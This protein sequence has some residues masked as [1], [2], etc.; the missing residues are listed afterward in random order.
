MMASVNGAGESCPSAP[1]SI[2]AESL[3]RT[4]FLTAHALE[5]LEICLKA[6]LNMAICG[7]AGSGKRALLHA[8]VPRMAGDGQ[9]LAIQ[10]PDEP[11]LE[12]AGVTSLRAH[13]E[14]ESEGLGITRRYLLTL[15][16]KMHPVGL[17]LDEVEGA[18]AAPLV[19]LLLVTD[20]VLFSMVATSPT[21]A[22]LTLESLA[23]EHETG[24]DPTLARRILST[25]LQL[26][27]QLDRAQDGG[28]IVISLTE[29][30]APEEG[31]YALRDIFALANREALEKALPGSECGLRATGLR[32]LFLKRLQTLGVIVPEH[33][34]SP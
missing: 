4:G 16:P 24:S 14:P 17:V 25:A 7:P 12:Q 30:A 18:E 21:E 20:G 1:G 10:N 31:A 32:P 8:L 28:S 5:F 29:V 3:T 23:R 19:K 9:I 13:L 2:D 22:L 11:S 26:I 15:V 34:F 33:V 27:I 6:R